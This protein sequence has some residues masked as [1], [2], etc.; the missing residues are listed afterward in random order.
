M[1]ANPGGPIAEFDIEVILSRRF[2]A[3]EPRVFEIGGRIPR[4]QDR[5]INQD[6]DC[7]ITIWEHWLATTEKHSIAAF[8]NGP[9]HQF[10]LGQYL[11]E[12]T[13]KWPFGEYP[14]GEEGLQE[15][16]A[17]VLVVPNLTYSSRTVY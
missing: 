15:A 12:K 13:G 5:H 11:F 2:P 14:H 17:D 6:G 10:F 7:C 8:L 9:L 1:I 3:K 4:D 16:Y